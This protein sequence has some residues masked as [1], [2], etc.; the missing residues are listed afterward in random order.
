MQYLLLAMISDLYCVLKQDWIALVKAASAAAKSKG[1]CRP[2][3]SANSNKDREDRT[4]LRFDELED[5]EDN[6]ADSDR[7]GTNRVSWSNHSC[8]IVYIFV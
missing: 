8:L 5:E 2:R 6:D 4:E 3:T 7:L 1:G